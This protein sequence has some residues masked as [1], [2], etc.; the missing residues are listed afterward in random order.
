MRSTLV[1]ERSGVKIHP[2]PLGSRHNGGMR[3][4]WSSIGTSETEAVAG[5]HLDGGLHARQPSAL[6]IGAFVARL[7]RVGRPED[8]RSD[9][10]HGQVGGE[11]A[12]D[13]HQRSPSGPESPPDAIDGQ[14]QT[15]RWVLP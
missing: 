6:P 14:V 9:L 11:A 2:H 4:F 8:L 13:G 1:G 15:Y 12:S 10:S 5:T 3:T 7:R